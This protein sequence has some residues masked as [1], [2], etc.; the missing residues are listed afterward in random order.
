[1]KSNTQ[2]LLHFT[3]SYAV[4]EKKKSKFSFKTKDGSAVVFC[5][6]QHCDMKI[7]FWTNENCVVDWVQF[8]D[9][10]VLGGRGQNLAFAMIDSKSLSGKQYRLMTIH[11]SL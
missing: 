2:N 3:L 7:L 1:M 6:E 8:L 5:M 4:K 11:E 10:G 9:L